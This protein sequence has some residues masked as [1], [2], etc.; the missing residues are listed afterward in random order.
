MDAS[1]AAVV[2]CGVLPVM[3]AGRFDVDGGDV[4]IPRGHFGRGYYMGHGLFGWG[5]GGFF[6]FLFM[7]MLFGFFFR[8]LFGWRRH[9]R[10]HYY[11]PRGH[12]QWVA[13]EEVDEPEKD[14]AEKKTSKKEK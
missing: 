7:F 10:R 5:F 8:M 2:Y 4:V 6:G 14:S 13:D 11:G 1:A 9:S 12:W 3:A